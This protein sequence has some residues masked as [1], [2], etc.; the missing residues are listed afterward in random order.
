[1]LTNNLDNKGLL[2]GNM[3]GTQINNYYENNY[4]KIPSLLSQLIK[5][6]SKISQ[7]HEFEDIDTI[8]FNPEE[9]IEY[10]NVIKYKWL[11]IEYTKFYI[12]CDNILNSLDNFNPGC[13]KKI[14]TSIKIIYEKVVGNFLLLENNKDRLAVIR[15]NADS[16]IDKI[17]EKLREKVENN[18]LDLSQEDI[19]I[20]L[21][22]II[23]YAFNECKILDKPKKE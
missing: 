8:P 14:L 3:I 23:C 12:N 9:K 7:E 1:M 19:D 2:K 6:L 16:L 20:G 10:N 17:E 11:L 21:L 22:I 5:E 18:N 13:K 4:S 15:N